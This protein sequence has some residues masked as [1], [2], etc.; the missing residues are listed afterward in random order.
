MGN[1]LT[2]KTFYWCNWIPGWWNI[3][4]SNLPRMC[5]IQWTINNATLLITRSGVRILHQEEWS[6]NI[7]PGVVQQYCTRSGL[8]I[9][10]RE[11][12]NNTVILRIHC[13]RQKMFELWSWAVNRNGPFSG[14]VFGGAVQGRKLGELRMGPKF[15]TTRWTIHQARR[16]ELG[17]LHMGPKLTTRR[18]TSQTTRSCGLGEFH[19]G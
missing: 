17:E 9:L 1:R 6:S 3:I 8:T 14:G 7:A 12:S 10:H 15:P 5:W 4:G 19:I 18:W 16:W 13:S 11:W 2:N